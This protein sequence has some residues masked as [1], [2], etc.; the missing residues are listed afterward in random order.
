MSKSKKGLQKA[1]VHIVFPVLPV[2]YGKEENVE[3]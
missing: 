1:V 2:M 3:E